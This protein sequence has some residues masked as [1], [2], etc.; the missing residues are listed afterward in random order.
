MLQRPSSADTLAIEEDAIERPR[1]FDEV[2]AVLVIDPR[3]GAGD[4]L[5]R[6]EERIGSGPGSAVWASSDRELRFGQARL[7]DLAVRFQP[8]LI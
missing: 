3:V 7:D 2:G 4:E 1:V 8:R 5:V 6:D